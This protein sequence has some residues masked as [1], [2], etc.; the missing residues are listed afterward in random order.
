MTARVA[1][2]TIFRGRGGYCAAETKRRSRRLY[3]KH[4]IIRP[5]YG[6][7]LASI[8]TG[9]SVDLW[10]GVAERAR[11][12]DVDLLIVPTGRIRA[13][14]LDESMRNV[15]V[16]L[17]GRAD[18]D[19][20]LSWASS[21]SGACGPDELAAIHARFGG[22]PMVSLAQRIEGAGSVRIDDYS[23]MLAVLSHLHDVHGFTR[24]AFIR[25]PQRHI[26]ANDRY[27]AYLD[28]LKLKGLAYD[29]ALVSEPL[30]WDEGAT[31]LEEFLDRRR[32]IPGESFQAIAAASDLLAFWFQRGVQERGYQVPADIAVAGINDS[33][34]S[35]LSAPPL[36]T[37]AMPFREQGARGLSLLHDMWEGGSDPSELVLPASLV[38]RESCGCLSVEAEL[39]GEAEAVLPTGKPSG[40]D[41]CFEAMLDRATRA[42]GLGDAEKEAWMRPLVQAFAAELETDHG[43]F[44]AILSRILDRVVHGDGEAASWQNALS[45]LRRDA[46]LA[47]PEA[48]LEKVAG[49]IARARVMTGQ[50][51]ARRGIFAGWTA[52]ERAKRLRS[53]G[54]ALLMSYSVEGIAALLAGRLPAMAMRH[55]YLAV[56]DGASTRLA[57]AMRDGARL[58]LTPGGPELG[59]P[60]WIPAEYLPAGRYSL[61]VEALH[62]GDEALGYLVLEAGPESGLVYEEIRG[63][64]SS[65]I[66]GALLFRDA[67]DARLR[68]ERA[69]KVKTR[70]LANVSHELRTPLGLIVEEAEGPAPDLSRIAANARYQMKLV[71]DLLD[72]SRA[73]IEE[74]DIAR[75]YVD[76]RPLLLECFS[77]FHAGVSGDVRWT[78]SLPERL[79]AVLADPARI[80]QILF[81][82]LENARRNTEHGSVGLSARV[83]PPWLVVE[84]RDTGPGIPR[85][86]LEAVFEPFFTAGSGQPGGVGLGL[87]ISRH[88]ALMHGGRIELDSEEG[89]GSAFR[90]VL[91]LPRLGPE[92]A[93]AERPG[94]ALLAIGFEAGLPPEVERLAAQRNLRIHRLDAGDFQSWESGSPPPSAIAI[95]SG[96]M[97]Q[98]GW[99]AL[100]RMRRDPRLVEAPLLLFDDQGSKGGLRGIAL[101]QPGANRE[102]ALMI[103]AGCG[104]GGSGPALIVDDDAA[105][106]GRMREVLAAAFPELETIEAGDV[107]S[108]MSAMAS[109]VPSLVLLDL[110]M[111]GRGGEELL[112]AMKADE[113]LSNVPV[114]VL[115]NKLLTDDDLRR[116]ERHS[117]LLVQSKGIWTDAELA[118]AARL[119]L[120]DELNPNARP[121]VKLALAWILRNYERPFSRWQLAE[122]IGVSED[123][124]SRAFHRELGLGVWEFLNRY[125]IRRARELLSATSLPV[126]EI[127]SSVGFS[128]QSYFCRVF[129]KLSGVSPVAFREH[130][131]MPL[132]S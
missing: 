89:A 51:L 119:A 56:R 15:L 100:R 55:A 132:K 67:Q 69:D 125:R 64:V 17:L 71:N 96:A 11:E 48:A 65:A 105:Q 35:R 6:F 2:A 5:C 128:D 21:L 120:D 66:K 111:P 37:I 102:L 50:A 53:L 93:A 33:P 62:V 54:R 104:L 76:P 74:I 83:D 31:A 38:V 75:E 129:R 58:E 12:L 115:T 52:E 94:D 77:S 70:L 30:P 4:A 113:R 79:P 126:G 95:D 27:R 110:V 40:D 72:L 109:R 45:S 43:R 98:P 68:A 42:A 88:L 41:D 22:K 92:T 112:D 18:V 78:A 101:K 28:F 124:L 26:S 23:G 117:R 127:A 81:N 57:L 20:L 123:H 122:A 49:L 10:R 16:D 84:V 118:A 108:A 7:M 103:E 80:R 1:G 60:G 73:E 9:A 14:E 36:T 107:D 24:I 13:P 97:G 99:K 8:H 61:I 106:R 29:P 116:L 87:A 47:A 131:S 25:G 59:E 86:R 63:Y 90:L 91:P 34:E 114:I 3:R 44:L 130:G 39:A 32:L 82:L 19:G 121:V 46:F 85:D